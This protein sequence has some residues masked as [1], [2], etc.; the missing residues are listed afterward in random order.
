MLD[1]ESIRKVRQPHYARSAAKAS[2]N[3]PTKLYKS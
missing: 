1:V 2:P 3:H